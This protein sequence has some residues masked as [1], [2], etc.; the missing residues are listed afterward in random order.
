[1]EHFAT[2]FTTL[3]AALPAS[4]LLVVGCTWWIFRG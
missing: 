4:L 2:L 1:M 3:I